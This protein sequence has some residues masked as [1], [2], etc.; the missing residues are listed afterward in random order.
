MN[1]P[2]KVYG[3]SVVNDA[4]NVLN[5]DY[6]KD[7]DND[8]FPDD[9]VSESELNDMRSELKNTDSSDIHKETVVTDAISGIKNSKA[10]DEEFD[11]IVEVINEQD[12]R[13]KT[14]TA[15]GIAMI[16]DLLKSDPTEDELRHMSEEFTKWIDADDENI[17]VEEAEDALG[18]RI[19]NELKNISGDDYDRIVTRFAIQTYNTFQKEV[20]YND[21]MK[22]LSK[23]AKIVNNYNN[24]V[25]CDDLDDFENLD[26]EFK[27][28]LDVQ[29]RISEFMNKVSKLDDR[30]KRLRQDYSIDDY[31]IKTVESVKE[32]LDTALDFTLIKNKIKANSKKFK[33]DFKDI[34]YVN[35]SIE[36]WI[37]DIRNDPETIFTFP[38]NDFLSL[39]ESR[40][41]MEKFIHTA[42]LSYNLPESIPDP[43]DRDLDEAMIEYD[44][45]TKED[46]N[47]Y[48][49]QSRLLLFALSR[50]FKHKKL[51]SNNDRRVLSY[52]LDIISKLGVHDHHKRVV[53]LVNWIYDY[54]YI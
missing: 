22:E 28:L 26:K 17:T 5:Y 19:I 4:S 3:E 10:T 12:I 32:C 21:D 38:V 45:I 43:G 41:Q 25:K 20:Q 6:A 24:S 50:T 31:D 40:E 37:N 29:D 27:N 1:K 49:F 2:N 39:K 52:T 53:E 13:G 18:E 35:S 36:N 51:T 54:L 33:K 23:L 7:L 15:S 30:N 34:T 8:T 48:I 11:K 47:K 16:K 14:I 44:I 9:E 42:I 46:N